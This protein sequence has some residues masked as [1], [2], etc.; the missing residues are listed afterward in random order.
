[1]FNL[2][3]SLQFWPIDPGNFENFGVLLDELISVGQSFTACIFVEYMF[4]RTYIFF[5]RV[6]QSILILFLY[7]QSF[8]VY[9]FLR[10]VYNLLQ[11]HRETPVIVSF[12]LQ[13]QG[14]SL[15]VLLK[16]KFIGRRFPVKFLRFPRT[17]FLQNTSGQF[18]V[19]S[20][21]VLDL[22]LV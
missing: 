3:K 6:S 17:K 2:A 5:P 19:I 1:M 12:L 4:C 7:S 13:L 8:L 18:S 16:R 22:L 11:I 21:N 15:T 10:R 20:S 9:S 14:S